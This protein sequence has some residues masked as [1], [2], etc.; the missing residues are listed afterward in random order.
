MGGL[1]LPG[2]WLFLAGVLAASILLAVGMVWIA[3]KTVYRPGAK[4]QTG[5]LSPFLTTVALVYGALLGFTVVVAW[6]QFSS[7]EENVTNESSTL[8]TMYR[9]T[10]SLPAPEQV[11]MRDLLRTY[12]V[13]AQAEWDARQRDVAGG[14][15][16]AAI[17]DMYRV[18][19]QQA[20]TA[21]PINAEIRE[22]LN[23]LTTQR[24]TRV[25]DAKPRIPGLLWSGLLFGAVLLIG[26]IGFTHL[27]NTLSHMVLSSAVAVL[28]GLLLFLIFWLDHP[29]GQ[30]LGVTPALFDYSVQVF[31]GVDQ[32]T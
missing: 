12:T 14:S 18:L 24:N 19:G 11:R 25:L 16:R 6:E 30:R 7:A 15:A 9:Q 32:G 26:L 21:D 31:D 10:V 27:G 29:F 13:A 22:Q 17:T 4:R 1:S 3:N 28:L 23:V 2:L 20:T 8:A 5:T